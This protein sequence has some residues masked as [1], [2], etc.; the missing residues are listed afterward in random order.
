MKT[1]TF[2]I[3]DGAGRKI[4]VLTYETEFVATDLLDAI[5]RVRHIVAARSPD[6]HENTAHI[7]DPNDG[8]LWTPSV[9]FLREAS[10]VRGEKTP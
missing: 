1:F 10:K 4:D 2:R 7:G 3:G 5:D 8:L 9:E 6:Q